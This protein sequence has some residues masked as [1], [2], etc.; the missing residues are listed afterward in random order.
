MK[1]IKTNIEFGLRR[2][3]IGPEL[4]SY[5]QE[6]ASA[7][8]ARESGTM[9]TGDHDKGVGVPLA[10]LASAPDAPV[11]HRITRTNEEQTTDR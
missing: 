8:H 1:D 5:L 2:S 6:M 3:D 4:S 7:L 10:A 11:T 9:T